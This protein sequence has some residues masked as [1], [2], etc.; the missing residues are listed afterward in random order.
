VL[1]DKK[2]IVYSKIKVCVGSKVWYLNEFHLFQF[3]KYL[4]CYNL[5]PLKRI[6]SRDSQVKI[7]RDL[8]NEIPG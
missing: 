6:S 8:R 2:L 7:K 5:P 4:G 1:K 3:P